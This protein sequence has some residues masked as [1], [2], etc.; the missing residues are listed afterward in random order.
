MKFIQSFK[1]FRKPVA[2]IAAF[3]ITFYATAIVAESSQFL[4]QW[5]ATILFLVGMA[6]LCWAPAA[7]LRDRLLAGAAHISDVATD[8]KR[9][10]NRAVL[11]IW[12]WVPGSFYTRKGHELWVG[13]AVVSTDDATQTHPVY[14][15]GERELKMLESAA[16]VA[17]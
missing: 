6:L 7:F 11:H 8:A 1:A 2:A 13:V 9:S 5:Q 4:R 12:Q 17:A 10:G 3:A 15:F 16:P 14:G